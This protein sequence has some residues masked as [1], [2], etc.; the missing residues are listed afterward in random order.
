MLLP[1]CS[2]EHSLTSTDN[3]QQLSSHFQ[4]DSVYQHDSVSFTYRTAKN[5]L[6]QEEGRSGVDT[7]YIER[8]HTRWRN[9]EIVRTDTITQTVTQSETIE[10]PYVPAF[11]KYCT[12]FAI[13]VVLVSIILL[14]HHFIKPSLKLWQK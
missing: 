13:I 1:A 9:H 11:Y 3:R 2:V 4:R 8:W 7:L 12:V 14:I 10:V 5:S 6:L